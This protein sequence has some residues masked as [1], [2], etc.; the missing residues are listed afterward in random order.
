MSCPN[1]ICIYTNGIV[2]EGTYM[3]LCMSSATQFTSCCCHC[4]QHMHVIRTSVVVAVGR[5][6]KRICDDIIMWYNATQLLLSFLLVV[7][8]VFSTCMFLEHLWLQLVWS[9]Y[10][11][12]KGRLWSCSLCDVLNQIKYSSISVQI[13]LNTWN[14]KISPKNKKDTGMAC[15]TPPLKKSH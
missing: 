8:M 2:L 14:K 10:S 4:F 5:N 1:N 9:Y 15:H 13:N 3:C 7:G 11:C 6:W 12:K